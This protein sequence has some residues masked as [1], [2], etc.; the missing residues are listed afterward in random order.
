M[1]PTLNSRIQVIK[2]PSPEAA[3]H[4]R[5]V[6]L[7]GTTSGPDDWRNSVCER[8]SDLAVTVYNP[9][10]PDWDSS[11]REEISCEPYRKQVEW[12]LEKQE[13]ADVIA[14]YFGADTDAPISLLELGLC[15]KQ[16][17]AIVCVQE[18]YKKKGNVQI[19]CQRY[20]AKL[21]DRV[22]N[23]CVELETLLAV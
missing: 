16:R 9:L 15:A 2:A 18:G 20:G 1:N 13:L 21:V 22:E 5:S 3:R 7:A 19:V 23:L 10:R 12:E 14:F 11:W 4:A 6:F 17:K 8:L